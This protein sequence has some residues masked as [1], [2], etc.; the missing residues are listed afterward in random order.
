[1][2]C[3]G[4]DAKMSAAQNLSRQAMQA[5]KARKVEGR[6]S[7]LQPVHDLDKQLLEGGPVCLPFL[8]SCQLAGQQVLPSYQISLQDLLVTE[9]ISSW[10]IHPPSIM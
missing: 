6:D 10:P 2:T 1:M 4:D 7:H 3:L 8:S 9:T 5:L